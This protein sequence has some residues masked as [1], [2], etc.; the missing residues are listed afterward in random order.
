MSDNFKSAINEISF[1]LGLSMETRKLAISAL[2]EQAIIEDRK[3]VHRA[4]HANSGYVYGPKELD[5]IRECLDREFDTWSAQDKEITR[6]SEKLKRSS[7]SV[8][9][10]ARDL[11]V[12]KTWDYWY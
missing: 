12:F 4:R 6:I 3:A 10:K 5:Y 8:K 9:Q 2:E 11:G 1:V 7:K